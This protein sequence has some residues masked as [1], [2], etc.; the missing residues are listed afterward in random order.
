[1]TKK[2]KYTLKEAKDWL[3]LHNFKYGK[4]DKRGKNLRFRQSDPETYDKLR[5]KNT[6]DGI[7]FIIGS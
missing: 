3:K 5:T 2:Y 1:M 7:S 4:V 6:S